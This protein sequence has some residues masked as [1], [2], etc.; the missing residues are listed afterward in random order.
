M[1]PS[2]LGL[3]D[4]KGSGICKPADTVTLSIN[5]GE[6]RKIERV[7]KTITTGFASRIDVKKI[8]LRGWQRH[9]LVFCR[10]LFTLLFG[11]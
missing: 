5:C 9:L 7:G 1:L 10:H 2:M 11:K 6:S 8:A 3:R 4:K